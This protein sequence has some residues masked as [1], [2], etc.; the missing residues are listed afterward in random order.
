MQAPR[1]SWPF[2]A[3][4]GIV[5]L[6]TFLRLPHLRLVPAWYPDEGSNIAIA[7]S[8]AQGE[9]AYLAFGRSSFIN[10]HP[11][12]LYLGMAVLFRWLGVDI[13]WARLLTVAL[14]L[15]TLV[16]LYVVAERMG[17]PR[18][19]WAAAAFYAIYPSAVVYNRM[20][21]TY[22]LIAPLYLLTLYAVWQA[23][24]ASRRHN[25]WIAVAALCVGFALLTDWVAVGL[26]AF[27]V[28]AL[29]FIRPKS[30]LWAV[31][32]AVLPFLVWC[33]VTGLAA[34]KAFWQDLIFTFSRT[35]AAL[36]IQVARIIFYR[37]TLEGDLWLTLGGLGL[38]L[39]GDR[40]A[41]WLTA[42]LVGL[43]LLILV[44]N[45]PASGQ[46]SYFLIPLFPLAAW[47]MG[48]L[49]VKGVPVLIGQLETAWGS[50]FSRRSRLPRALNSL[51]LFLLIIA[52]SLSMIAE[53]VWLD[54]RLYTSRFGE[55]L[56]DPV[57]AEQAADYVNDRTTSN[58]VVLVSPT[59]AWLIR[60]HAA[61]F[62]M[63]VAAT[64]QATA[65][66]PADI[67]WDR[68]RFDPRLENAKYVIVD[69]LWRT[70]ASDQ[71]PEVAGMVKDIESHWKLETQIG[72]FEI[73]HHPDQ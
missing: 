15:L 14:G 16:L 26:L 44:R 28:L 57:S 48:V 27:L 60:A 24:D 21:L 52:P 70:W 37:T 35:N 10:G 53:G 25:R 30:L 41:R 6:A 55:T 29:L 33:G 2:F 13:L 71:M 43:S 49:L 66:F 67:P 59:I 42:G 65:H 19:A 73:Y 3:L 36:P 12:L 69:P 39:Q 34:G 7:A 72:S 20:A 4:V 45:G 22:N 11:P 23:S 8:L 47:G 18:V 56:A 40:H 17:G 64:G 61:D 63:A 1:F 50:V 31:P 68:F 5:A 51:I 58:D 46:A 62:Q 54:Y 32:L 38:L 9:S